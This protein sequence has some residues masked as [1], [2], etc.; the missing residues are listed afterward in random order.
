M[1][2]TGRLDRV[3]RRS[4]EIGVA[5]DPA[6][7]AWMIGAGL[8]RPM[9]GALGRAVAGMDKGAAGAVI[10]MDGAAATLGMAD[11][12]EGAAKSGMA[13]E[14]VAG[15]PPG[16]CAAALEFTLGT[17]SRRGMLLQAACPF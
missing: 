14:M 2:L 1:G 17:P 4:A 10:P 3:S 6:G 9:L 5:G 16:V 13:G 12:S 7:G 8:A 15:R 11:P